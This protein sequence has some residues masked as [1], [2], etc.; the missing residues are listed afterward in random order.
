M[1]VGFT[2]MPRR[3]TQ[4]YPGANCTGAWVGPRTILDGRGQQNIL[5]TTHY[6]L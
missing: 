5:V 2:A 1:G 4:G 3:Y 6:V